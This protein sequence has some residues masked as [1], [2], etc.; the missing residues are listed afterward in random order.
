[1]KNTSLTKLILCLFLLLSVF[2]E[3]KSHSVQVAYCVDCAGNLRVF[4]EHW[5]GAEA[6]NTTSMT[7]S[8]AVNNVTTTQT[9]SPI[10]N[11][12]I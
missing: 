8:L 7:I 5:H 1:M 2:K 4:I 3:V 12:Q 11:L 9:Q 10:A 6:A